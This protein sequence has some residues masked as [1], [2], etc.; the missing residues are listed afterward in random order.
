M[1]LAIPLT[2][3]LMTLSP[4][5]RAA[6]STIT[7]KPFGTTSAGEKVTQ[8]TLR[9]DQG[10]S[11]SII[12]YGGIV[13]SLKVPDRKG[14]YDDVVLGFKTLAEYE[15]PGPYF[16]ALIGRYGNRIANGEFTLDRKTYHLA[17][18][19]NGQALHG[20]LKGFEKVIWNATPIETKQGPSLKLTYVSKDGEEGYPG[21]LSVTAVYTLT[22]RN[23]L[24]I[25]YRAKTDKATIVNLTHHSYFNLAGQG[26]GDILDHLVT[27][28]ANKYTP[29]DKVLIPTGK[30]AAVKGTPFDF[31]KPTPIGARINEVNEQLKNGKGYDHNWI[32]D[33]LPGHLG[34]I[35]RVEEPNSGR[36]ME[37]ISTEPGIQFYSGNFLDGTIIGKG[38]KVYG[39]RNG[40]CFEPQH[41]P[42]SPNHKN[43]P[44]TELRPGETYKNTIIYRF[45]TK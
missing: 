3:F 30:L 32:A 14:K 4:M 26:S 39:F 42:D 44:S 7:T 1:K 40:F 23:E 19:N 29:V 20:G 22:N 6:S 24:K 12:N 8:Y 17:R 45:S 13:T 2:L 5:T 41:F 28:H 37:V 35:A 9:N 34:M 15:K 25:V 36:V 18:N 27:I 33:K 16:G 21:K 10:A 31:R 38:N 43:F 11:V